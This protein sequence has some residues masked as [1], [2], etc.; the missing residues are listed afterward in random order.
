MKDAGQVLEGIEKVLQETFL[1]HLFFGRLETLL[2]VVGALI[3]LLLNKS[4]LGLYNPVT[5]EKY[6][7]TSSLR[8]ICEMIGAVTGERDFQPFI[9]FRW[10]KRS[11][12][13]RK[14]LG[15]RE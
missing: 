10:L 12:R 15:C 7:Y 5:S 2:P 9:T 6:K 14:I 1:P 4:R 8:T 13:T 11:G 3:M